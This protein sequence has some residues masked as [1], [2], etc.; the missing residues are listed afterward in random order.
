MNLHLVGKQFLMMTA[1]CVGTEGGSEVQVKVCGRG[2]LGA[3]G[4]IHA[5]VGAA[6][7]DVR[8]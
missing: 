4:D 2:A 3:R 1:R 8:M 6:W 7:E 5:G